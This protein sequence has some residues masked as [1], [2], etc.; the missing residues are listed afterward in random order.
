MTILFLSLILSE[1]HCIN[2]TVNFAVLGNTG[3]GKSSV[4]NLALNIKGKKGMMYEEGDSS[5]SVT[6]TP[7]AV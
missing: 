1:I 3:Q 4:L 2:S 5:H 7:Q 6:K